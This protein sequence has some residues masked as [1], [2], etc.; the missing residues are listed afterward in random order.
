MKYKQ[1]LKT[2]SWSVKFPAVRPSLRA[3]GNVDSYHAVKTS[4]QL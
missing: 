3:I 4:L 2:V 1:L